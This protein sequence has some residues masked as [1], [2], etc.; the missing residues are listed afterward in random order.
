[1]N[2]AELILNKLVSL[3][4]EEKP[5]TIEEDVIRRVVTAYIQYGN[6]CPETASIIMDIFE[7]GF[8]C[9]KDLLDIIV[10]APHMMSFPG[11]IK[12]GISV[13]SFVSCL[14]GVYELHNSGCVRK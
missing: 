12:R 11:G 3:S 7:A 10:F 1:M 6:D 9:K 4:S 2:N 5:L 14:R 13:K 8:A